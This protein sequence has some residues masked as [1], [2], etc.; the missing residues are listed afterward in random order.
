MV[1]LLQ[2]D[3]VLLQQQLDVVRMVKNEAYFVCLFMYYREI[4][5]FQINAYDEGMINGEYIYFGNEMIG[6]L[7][8]TSTFMPD[9]DN[10][11]I[12]EGFFSLTPRMEPSPLWDQLQIDIVAAFNDSRFDGYDVIDSVDEVDEYAGECLLL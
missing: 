4:R 3:A 9:I 2:V 7:N 1:L 6:I 10:D 11:V 12:F 5:V 8:Q